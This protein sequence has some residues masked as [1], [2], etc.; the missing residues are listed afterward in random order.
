MGERLWGGEAERSRLWDTSAP[1]AP[2]GTWRKPLPLPES[3]ASYHNKEADGNRLRVLPGRTGGGRAG[4]QEGS[5]TRPST[6]PV[7]VREPCGCRGAWRRRVQGQR[8]DEGAGQGWLAGQRE[9]WVPRTL[10]LE[11]GEAG[12]KPGRPASAGEASPSL[13]TPASRTWTGTAPPAAAAAEIGTTRPRP[14]LDLGPHY[15]GS[16]RRPEG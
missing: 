1:P 6:R 2:G 11:S 9:D 13:A 8:W 16:A 3:E 7:S 4:V 15:A 12:E 14:G 10:L 5:C